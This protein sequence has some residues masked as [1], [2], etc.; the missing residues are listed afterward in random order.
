MCY[1]LDTLAWSGSDLKSPTRSLPAVR[2][3]KKNKTRSSFFNQHNAEVKGDP[4]GWEGGYSKLKETKM[5]FIL[6][7]KVKFSCSYTTEQRNYK[8]RLGNELDTGCLWQED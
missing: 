5:T 6:K 1:R 2:G 7:I 4:G 8:G 3:K